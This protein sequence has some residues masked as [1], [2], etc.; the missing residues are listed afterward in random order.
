MVR[1]VLIAA[2]CEKRAN[3]RIQY[4]LNAK[5]PTSALKINA[6]FHVIVSTMD[7]L[8]QLQITSEYPVMRR[9]THELALERP[10][11]SSVV[12]RGTAC[13]MR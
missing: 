12:Q 10:I 5:T 4:A 13:Q 3:V 11:E 1:S 7:P 8:L 9:E 2:L 6:M